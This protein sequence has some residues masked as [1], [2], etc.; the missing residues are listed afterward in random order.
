VKKIHEV[1]EQ[2][3]KENKLMTREVRIWYTRNQKTKNMN[4]RLKI[5][6]I[7]AKKK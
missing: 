6:L 2:L 1:K 7:Q 3:K 5:K 4:I